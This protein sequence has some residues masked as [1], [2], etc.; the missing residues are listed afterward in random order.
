MRLHRLTSVI[1]PL[2]AALLLISSP[3][4]AETSKIEHRWGQTSVPENPERIV[5]LSYS[6]VDTLLALGLRPLA[7]RAWYGGNEKGLWPWAAARMPEDLDATVLRGEIDAESVARLQPDFVEAIYS[8][9]TRAQYRA[10]SRVAPVLPAPEG[11]GDFGSTWE[12]MLIGVGRATGRLPQAQEMIAKMEADIAAVRAAHP[13]WQ[14]K[15]AI[16][17]LPD[18]PLVFSEIDPRMDL[19]KRLGFRLPEAARGLALGGFFFKLDPELT[20]PIDADVVLWLDLGGGVGR[21][22]AHPLR[23]TLRAVREGR[24]VI[25]GPELS[26]AL[27]YASPLSLPYALERL[28]PMLETALDGNPDT[29]VPKAA[30]TGPLQ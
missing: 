22:Y 7:Y 24:E 28:V 12:D 25:V 15:T 6:G 30:G 1:S 8:G 19:M 4:A 29:R 11:K 21:L 18:T 2:V 27:S 17:G 23:H 5:S 16:V 3:A 26:A 10:L 9:L 20:A 13:E 14:G